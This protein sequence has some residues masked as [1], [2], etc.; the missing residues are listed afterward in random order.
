MFSNEKRS[1]AFLF[2]SNRQVSNHLRQLDDKVTKPFCLDMQ[3]N[4]RHVLT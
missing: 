2:W 3:G 1:F 4:A